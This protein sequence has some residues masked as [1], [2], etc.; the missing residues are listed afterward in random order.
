[1]A[2]PTPLPVAPTPDPA[3]LGSSAETSEAD[4]ARRLALALHR[5]RPQHP[6][7]DD[8]LARPPEVPAGA[9]P[10]DRRPVRVN[11]NVVR[12]VHRLRGR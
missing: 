10:L 3:Q 6:E 7:A 5:A 4:R 11:G 8:D 9:T 12:P 2:D 1:M